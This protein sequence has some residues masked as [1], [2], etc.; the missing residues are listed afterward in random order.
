MGKLA[1]RGD[2]IILAIIL[3]II[4]S[5]ISFMSFSEKSAPSPIE[6]S[7]LG[8]SIRKSKDYVGPPSYMQSEKRE[9]YPK[10]TII[11]IN[12]A[13]S[14][15]LT[16]I[17]GIGESFAHR[18]IS[19]RKKLGGFY[20]IEQLQEVYGM[21]EDKYLSIKRW[22]AIKTKQKTYYIDELVADELPE[23]IYLSYK[24]KRAMNKILYRKGKINSW[25]ELMRL[26]EFSYD[27]SVR[28]SHYIIEKH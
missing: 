7:I 9:K 10:G 28:L 21:D 15:S 4:A 19:L 23:I 16:K 14:I 26:E 2:W 5:T 12:T 17:P 22:F 8:D 6:H 20:T 3:I 24:Q 1:S 27:D 18:I 13:D 11:D 25:K